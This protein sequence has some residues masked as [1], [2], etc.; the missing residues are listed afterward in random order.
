MLHLRVVVIV[1]SSLL[2]G[3][4]INVTKRVSNQL[5]LKNLNQKLET[6]ISDLS[7]DSRCPGTK[8]LRVIN[9]ETRTEKYCVNDAMGCK[10]YVIPKDMTDYVVKYIENKFRESNI[11]TGEEFDNEILVS[12]DEMKAIEGVWSFG[13]SSKIKIQ[14]PD[15][16]YTQ[17][18]IGESGS[19]LG[20]HAVAYAIHLSV[21]KFLKDP[22]FQNYVK[23]H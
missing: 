16:N 12:L 17:T 22:V 10:W 9:V 2:F 7:V 21:D 1:L 6:P 14:I 19:G 8:S 4:S 3:C 23:C 11:K 18:Y 13:S 15:L 20:F 5:D